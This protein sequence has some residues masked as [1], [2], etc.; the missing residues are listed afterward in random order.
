MKK[1]KGFIVYA[2][3][4][5]ALGL[6][7]LAFSLTRFKSGT[8]FRL[9]KNMEQ[10]KMYFLANAALNEITAQVKLSV[11][12]TSS[13][14]G[15]SIHGLW[16]AQQNVT[17]GQII[18]NGTFA[19]G[20]L[21]NTSSL[22]SAHFEE[23]CDI[24]AEA[25]LEAVSAFNTP[26][27][28]YLCNLNIQVTA[29]T[30]KPEAVLTLTETREVKIIDFAD[31]FVDKYAL[32]LKDF[33][34]QLNSDTSKR[35]TIEGYKEPGK[36][37]FIYLGNRGYPECNAYPQGSKSNPT[38][39]T[40]FDIDADKD[41][42][43]LGAS[44]HNPAGFN[45]QDPDL[46]TLTDKKLFWVGSVTNFSDYSPQFAITSH[47]HQVPEIASF[48]TQMADAARPAYRPGEDIV[49]ATGLFAMWHV[50]QG[51]MPNAESFRTLLV[52]CIKVW[53]YHFG[54]IDYTNIDPQNPDSI[55]LKHPVVASIF[56]YFEKN[57]ESDPPK[58]FGGKMPAIF[59]PNRD[60][61]AFVEGPVNLRFFKL[62]M[63]DASAVRFP[64]LLGSDPINL[65][66]IALPYEVDNPGKTF[67]SVKLSSPIDPYSDVLMSH[68]VEHLPVNAPNFDITET[69]SINVASNG[70]EQVP[71]YDVFPYTIPYEAISHFYTSQD[72]FYSE[73]IIE[74]DGKPVLYLDGLT[75]V[76]APDTA[77][78]LYGVEQ[79]TGNGKLVVTRGN[80]AIGNLQPLNPPDYLK[81]Y[82]MSGRFYIGGSEPVTIK[83]SLSS[84]AMHS[85]NSMHSTTDCGGL[86]PKNNDVTIEGNLLVDSFFDM[87][88][89]KNINIKHTKEVFFPEYPVRA[90]VGESAKAFNITY[91]EGS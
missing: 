26:R 24:T 54:F 57:A 21:P 48:Y 31:P 44:F 62:G 6:L 87:H 53:K 51:G 3:A 37:S 52:D 78:N 82:L 46:K 84:M 4:A 69:A 22:K 29:S 18:W 66:A 40:V 89:Y 25:K 39:F 2:V 42:K 77:L 19:I 30:T 74:L 27:A 41:K 36:Y 63:V 72:T 9:A 45:S 55:I 33:C 90:S 47:Y 88:T 58:A 80:L 43:L 14:L 7:L 85:D 83:A 76:D 86:L 70:T 5:I 68:P 1:K 23:T 15:S 49:S 13:S 38:P 59:G 8:I 16:S 28:S 56:P 65:P 12:D 20:D 75:I 71:G 61:P 64:A 17:P 60:I 79:Y 50:T 10:E 32:F 73:R 81:I 35:L 67:A 11:N 34:L 91:S